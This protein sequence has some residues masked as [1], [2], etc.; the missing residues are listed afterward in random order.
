LTISNLTKETAAT[1]LY[2]TKCKD[3]T[4]PKDKVFAIYRYLKHLDVVLPP[5]DYSESVDTI[6]RE[7]AVAAIIHDKSLM[8]MNLASGSLGSVQR[9]LE[10]PSWVP[11]WSINSKTWIPKPGFKAAGES[12]ALCRFSDE[13]DRLRLLGKSIDL[14]N[15]AI[16]VQGKYLIEMITKGTVPQQNPGSALK[17]IMDVFCKNTK[18]WRAKVL[19]R[20]I[21]T[22]LIRRTFFTT[23]AGYMGIAMRPVEAGDILV[24]LQ[25]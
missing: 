14:V 20:M 8:V 10:L 23:S 2:L 4:D 18:R 13:F 5:V 11:D 24:L 1:L 21:L 9:R 3:A 16:D 17:E 7:V 15:T 22:E 6:Y 12:E 25:A 19:S